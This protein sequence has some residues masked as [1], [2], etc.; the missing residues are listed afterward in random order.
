VHLRDLEKSIEQVTS[1]PFWQAIRD[2]DYDFLISKGVLTNQQSTFINLLRGQISEMSTNPILKKIFGK[3]IAVAIYPPEKDLD[4]FVQDTQNFDPKVAAELLSGLFVVIR[5]DPEIQFVEFIARFVDQSSVDISQGQ[6]EYKEKVIHTVEF[7]NGNM[8]IGIVRLGDLLVF[9]FGETAARTS[10]DVFT[11]SKTSLARDTQ[12][13]KIRSTFL[14]PANVMVFFDFEA[15]LTLIKDRMGALIDSKTAD[16]DTSAQAQ[17]EDALAKISSFKTIAFSSQLK[18]L[19]RFNSSLVFDPGKLDAE[20]APVYTCPPGENRTIDFVPKDVLGYQ[21][22]N[23]FELDYYWTQI[24]KEVAQLG[25]PASKID[26]FEAKMG[27]S[28]ED[29][30]LPAF[31]DEIGGYIADIQMGGLV[32]IPKILL[33]TEI[34][35]KS[36]AE[37]LLGKLKTH[38]LAVFQ[39][40]N[41]NGIPIKYI[42]L[43]FGESVQP[44]YCFLGDYLLIATSRQLLRGSIDTFGNTSK[45]LRADRDFRAIDFGLTDKNRGIYF[46][47]IGQVIDKVKGIVKWVNQWVSAQEQKTQAFKTGSE[48]PL[49]EA[50]TNIAVKEG[51]LKELRDKITL[52][53]DEIWSLDTKGEDVSVQQEQFNE[54]KSQIEAKELEVADAR[55]RRGELEKIVEENKKSASDPAKRQIY[56]DKVVYPVLDGLKSIESFGLRFTSEDDILSSSASIKIEDQ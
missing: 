14:N 2:V 29:D 17:W 36:K 6:V 48:K 31:G 44:G 45:S 22:S 42:A 47:K 46:I 39:D 9:G 33:F 37:H 52:L 8:T 41:Y 38:P 10:I 35:N 27:L 4:L 26:E 51:E 7:L 24:K 56:L 25:A 32:P 13:S 30:I 5:A 55:E 15:V 19:V 11:W 3:E 23:C 21:W 50:E 49:K 40:E 54:L 53:E 18:S 12:F 16:G 28:V 20:Y 1:M 34:K 43:P